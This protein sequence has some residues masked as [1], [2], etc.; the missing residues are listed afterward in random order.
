MKLSDDDKTI[1][2]DLC[3]QYDVS[4]EKVLLLLETVKE[5]ELKDRRTGL[6]DALKEIIKNDIK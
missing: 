1:L 5:Y 2:K 4:I 6:Y 3:E